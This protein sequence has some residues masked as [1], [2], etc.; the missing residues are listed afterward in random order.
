[1]PGAI[2]RLY[3]YYLIELIT[4]LDSNHVPILHLLRNKEEFL[5]IA[6]LV[7]GIARVLGSHRILEVWAYGHPCTKGYHSKE[8]W[9]AEKFQWESWQQGGSYAES[10]SE[11]AA[12]MNFISCTPGS[13]EGL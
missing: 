2:S 7:S 11:Q 5:K 4:I 13:A 1:M 12:E 8:L 9:V 10:K 6:K 3:M